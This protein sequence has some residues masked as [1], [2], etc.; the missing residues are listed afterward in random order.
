MARHERHI[1]FDEWREKFNDHRRAQLGDRADQLFKAPASGGRQSSVSLGPTGIPGGRPAPGSPAFGPG[2]NPNSK[3]TY[4]RRSQPPNHIDDV[5]MSSNWFSPFEPVA[6]FGPPYINQPREWDF[7]TGYNLN[8]IPQRME[9]NSMLRGMARTWGVMSTVI[10]TRMDQLLRIPW[11]IQQRDKPRAQNAGV[12]QMRKF[13]RKPD[14][15]NSYSQWSR[16]ILFDLFEIDAPCIYFPLDRRGRPIRAETLSGINIF[17]LIDDAGRRPDT[18]IEADEEGVTY[19]R[20]QPAYQQIIKGMPMV[21]LDEQEIL[22][23]PMRPRPDLPMF[24]YPPTEQILVEATEA[25][26]KTFYQLNFWEEGTIPDLIVTVPD[27][28]SP[29]QIAMFQ[30]HMDAM[31]S[32][33]LKLKSK[34]RFLPGGMKPFDVKNSSGESLWSQ[35]DET[36]IRLVCYAYSVSPAPFIKMLNRATAQNAQE[37][38]QQEGLYPLMSWWKDDIMDEIIT[39]CG[40]DDVEFIYLPRPELDSEKQAKIH[41]IQ[42]DTGVRNRNEVREELGQEAIQNGD[43]YTIQVGNQLIPLDMAVRGEAVQGPSGAAGPGSV[44]ANNGGGSSGSRSGR[45][46]LATHGQTQRGLARP[47]HASPL[48]S[49][50]NKG[51]NIRWDNGFFKVSSQ[52]VRSA[53]AEAGGDTAT[54]L[55]RKIGNYNKGHIWIQGLNISIEHKKGS[56]R[57]E[58]VRN[59]KKREIRVAAPYGYIRG[60]LGADGMQVD[61]YIGKHPES[62]H[63]WVIDQNEVSKKG[64]NKGFD[65]HKVMLGYKTLKRAMRDYLKSHYDEHSHK[66]IKAITETTVGDLKDWLAG[67]DMSRPIS[68]QDVGAVVLKQKDLT[69]SDTVSVATGL[70]WYDQVTAGSVP[71]RRKRKSKRGA[72]WKQLGLG[73]AIHGLALLLALGN[74]SAQQNY[75]TGISGVLVSGGALLVPKADGS[76]VGGLSVM[77]PPSLTNPLPVSTLIW[78]R[79]DVTPVVQAAAYASGNSIGGLVSFT[80]PRVASGFLQSLAVQFIGGATTQLNAYC[81]DANPTGSTFTDKGAFTIV[82]A[83]EAKRINKNGIALTPVAVVGDTVSA[84]S[85]DNYAKPFAS[86]GTIWCGFVSTGTFTPAAVNDMRVSITYGQGPL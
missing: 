12:E 13:F 44:P 28:W 6:P 3:Y 2:Q 18:I 45:G 47:S 78:G 25:I 10:S 82:A 32:G 30:G 40:I 49:P 35:R 81:F 60:T 56:L 74:A 54:H 8:Y 51:T 52:D 41:Q 48:P 63:V 50:A 23:A 20:R 62:D 71:K 34:I 66:R 75:P 83:D 67:G 27:N 46:G 7:P 9:L 39:R 55:Q 77:V 43:V 36:L 22:Y 59:G 80:L 4:D 72:R 14:Q 57:G 73:T 61:V 5:D 58:K 69:K 31:L 65:E 29:R 19:L 24:G 70:N 76:S 26:R 33:N 85:L 79:S 16:K 38:A 42:V 1:D 86:T 37:T 53:A 68:K 84:A 11:T 64:K 15:K 17:P 21:N